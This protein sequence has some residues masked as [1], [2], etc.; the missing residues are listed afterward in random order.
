MKPDN[1]I[2]VCIDFWPL[3][4]ITIKDIYLIPRIDDILDQLAEETIFSTFDATSEYYQIGLDPADAPKTAFAW[5]GR[6]LEF[7]RMPFRLCNAPATFQRAMD[8][9]FH[10]RSMC[11][12]LHTLMMP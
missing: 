11:V 7:T 6:L 1:K 9:I 10:R 8:Q 12:H 2:R 3:N 5:Q 4:D